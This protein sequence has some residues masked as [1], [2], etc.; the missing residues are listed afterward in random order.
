MKP[1]PGFD[2]LFA[3]EAGEIFSNRSGTLRRL[4][5]HIGKM[6]Y[7]EVGVWMRDKKCSQRLHVHV[8]VCSAFHG[9]RPFKGAQVRHVDGV[10][11]N[12]SA[13]NLAWGTSKENIGDSIRHG[14]WAGSKNGKRT[15]IRRVGAGL[16]AYQRKDNGKWYS[17]ISV[18]RKTIRLGQFPS[19]EAARKAYLKAAIGIHNRIAEELK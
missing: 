2:G 5:G 14:T 12:N 9:P 11:A 6:G 19:K 17:Q 7:S 3:T 1:V 13:A 18:G 4:A 15:A 10:K 16:G 8:A